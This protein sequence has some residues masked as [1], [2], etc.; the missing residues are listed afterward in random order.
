MIF[1]SLVRVWASEDTT[2][3][4]NFFQSSFRAGSEQFQGNIRIDCGQ[5]EN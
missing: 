3:S 1:A 5:P 2:L 4:R